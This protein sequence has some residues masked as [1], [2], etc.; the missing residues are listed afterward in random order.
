ML[1]LWVKG[2]LFFFLLSLYHKEHWLS[3]YERMT[4]KRKHCNLNLV[5]RFK[6]PHLNPS[7]VD[8]ISFGDMVVSLRYLPVW[9]LKNEFNEYLAGTSFY[10]QHNSASLHSTWKKMLKVVENTKCIDNW[11]LPKQ[12]IR[13]GALE[14]GV[15]GV[16]TL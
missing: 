16:S 9:E 8:S 15:C 3:D 2:F 13:W 10:A 12:T 7:P 1:S 6:N 14:R 5:P 11:Y 4:P